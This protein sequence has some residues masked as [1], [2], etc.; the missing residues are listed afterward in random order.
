MSRR[1][2][3]RDE[4]LLAAYLDDELDA[5]IAA[6]VEAW[7]AEDAEARRLLE[8]L[9]AA[10]GWL[11]AGLDPVLA[12]PPPADLLRRI[13][14]TAAGQRRAPAR[15]GRFWRG[16]GA[17][18]MPA[19]SMSWA[20]ATAVLV[21]VA[22]LPATWFVSHERG[23][24]AERLAQISEAEREKRVNASLETA[25]QQALESTVSGESLPWLAADEGG[26][27]GSVELVRTYK[28]SAGQWC[29]EYRIAVTIDGQAHG[30]RG[31][32]CRVQSS[33]GAPAHWER[34]VLFLD[35]D[36]PTA[37]DQDPT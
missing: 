7:L 13:E 6:D 37:V 24:E 2:L 32:A 11:R 17:G 12:E 3:R 23:R 9:R 5:G 16:R 33:D 4:A 36:P 1:T 21:L 25:L 14:A 19:S 30:E 34:K 35:D 31:I 27:S 26:G 22:G 28:S 29:R 8:S 15:I 20:L 10:D 18:G